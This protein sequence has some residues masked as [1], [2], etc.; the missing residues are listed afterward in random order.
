MFVVGPIERSAAE[1]YDRGLRLGFR[2]A[3]LV[4]D[5]QVEVQCV[6]ERLPGGVPLV[7]RQRGAHAA[8][9]RNQAADHQHE[10]AQVRDEEADLRLLPREADQ[11]RGEHVEPQQCVQRG[12][13]PTP[14]DA[15]GRGRRPVAALDERGPDQD[16]AVDRQQHHRQRQRRGE[17]VQ[18][19]QP[20]DGPG[21]V[22]G[23]QAG[24]RHDPILPAKGR[25][26]QP[27]R[28]VAG[29][30]CVLHF[31]MS[32]SRALTRPPWF[33]FCPVRGAFDLARSSFTIGL[34]AA[35]ARV[36]G[37]NG[38]LRVSTRVPP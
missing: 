16:Q 27:P 26:E 22:G 38:F 23:V 36:P 14:V 15:E 11:R 8:P 3:F 7:D 25:K 30:F 19:Q 29:P 12:E 21:L 32:G 33:R 4:F 17:L 2:V 35:P 28:P 13:P 20:A 5:A 18:P 9:P 34:L 24:T 37:L 10:N 6:L 31:P 1:T